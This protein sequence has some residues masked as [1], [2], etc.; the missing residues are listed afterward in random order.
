MRLTS[1]LSWVVGGA[2]R[3]TNSRSMKKR[4]VVRFAP[5][6]SALEDRTVPNGYLAIGAGP[7][8]YPE[9]A[10]RVDIQDALGGSGPNNAG[11]PAAPRSDGK[12]D[13]TSQVF[14]AYNPSFRGGV[15]VATGNFDGNFNTPDSLITAPKAGG[16]PHVIIWNT[17]QN[18]DGTIVVTGIKQQFFAFDPRFT[19]GV[20][21]TTGDLDGD[22]KAELIVAAG[23]GGGP[24]VKI[25]SPDA[26]GM[27]QLVDQF[28]AY[29]PTFRGGVS[30]ASNQGYSTQI[31]V[32]DVLSA[33]LPAGFS[34]T[35]YPP[36][37]TPPGV[38]NGFPLVGHDSPVLPGGTDPN[39]GQI[40]PTGNPGHLD[41]N[42]VPLPYITVGSGAIQYLSGN[43][44]NSYAQILYRPNDF[45]PPDV[46]NTG[47]AGNV[48]F[49]NWAD[50]TAASNYPTDGSA[51]PTGVPV[52]PYVQLGVTA[53]GTPI[54]TRLTP[55]PGQQSP[56]DQLITG[57]GPGGGPHVRI[58]GFTG[59]GA[60]M[61]HFIGK[62]FFAFAPTFTGGIN[63]A[64]G[65]VISNPTP[66][67]DA[68]GNPTTLPGRLTNGNFLDPFLVETTAN[69]GTSASPTWPIDPQ[70]FRKYT[71]EIIVT[72]ASR[73]SLARIF[74]DDNPAVTD[75]TNPFSSPLP[76][77]RG[78]IPELN[79]VFTQIDTRVVQDNSN[80]LGGFTSLAS[81]AD[82][83]RG[84]D[85]QF[86]GG[87]NS[88]VAAFTFG[89]SANNILVG[90]N[91]LANSGGFVTNPVLGQTVFAAGSG[92]SAQS[93]GAHIRIFN[94]MSQLTPT[95]A[96]GNPA[97]VT[98]SFYNPVDDF[99][100][101][102]NYTGAGATVSFGFGQLP[103]P[104]LD[105]IAFPP[106]TVTTVTN[107]ILV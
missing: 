22:G 70:L 8:F 87:L 99:F 56:R 21:I 83:N 84:I 50:T 80:P 77:V 45:V 63:V 95:V 97:Q 81:T 69:S 2:K 28:Y 66:S 78:S 101:F 48:V 37:Q 18:A 103:N 57:A 104:G 20:N 33:Q 1:L 23:P 91:V 47:N 44:L 93:R 73:G 59:S 74:S 3:P 46:T 13:F 82:F 25:Y 35:P 86:T 4:S 67:T 32:R 106:A 43:L 38:A 16:G 6:L 29:A 76:S 36:G 55:P 94:Q 75:P 15:N 5:V 85:P 60:T 11:Q 42:R 9:V 34:T 52:G 17:M 27:L 51:P 105:I 79:L 19:G 89:G 14:M 88:T 65:D 102:N 98:S 62:E 71:P 54:I 39:T 68:N 24:H 7:G 107:P 12:T 92:A 31:Q 10:I 100:G 49:A 26:N 53:T 40:V 41:N 90:T 64:L 30:V 72:Q 96:I 61:Q 58:W